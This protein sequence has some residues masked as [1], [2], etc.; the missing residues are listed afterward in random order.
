MIEGTSTTQ[1]ASDSRLKSG[2][3]RIRE[4]WE[5]MDAEAY[6]QLCT[7]SLLSKRITLK[8]A[9]IDGDWLSILEKPAEFKVWITDL[10]SRLLLSM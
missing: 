9:S 7:R 1:R 4:G 5:S 10:P 8:A 2:P 3:R 6:R